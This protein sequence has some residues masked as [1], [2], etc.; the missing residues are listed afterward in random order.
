MAAIVPTT[1]QDEDISANFPWDKFEEILR[2]NLPSYSRPQFVRFTR[3]IPTTATYKH[4]KS[5]LVTQVR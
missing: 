3:R 5:V 1:L 2:Q 4:L